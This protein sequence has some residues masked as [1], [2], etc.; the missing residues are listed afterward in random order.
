MPCARRCLEVSLLLEQKTHR[1]PKRNHHETKG[2]LTIMT[3]AEIRAQLEQLAATGASADQIDALTRRWLAIRA[4]TPATY[5][6][7][8]EDRLNALGITGTIHLTLE[9]I[10]NSCI[11]A[12][13][14]VW[15]PV[16]L[17]MREVI[18]PPEEF[19]N[20]VN[21]CAGW[22]D[23]S[24]LMATNAGYTVTQ[25][26]EAGYG[27]VVTISAENWQQW[28]AQFEVCDLDDET[29]AALSAG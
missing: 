13:S 15:G 24:H 14:L 17:Q 7:A 21:D 9:S 22:E 29:L 25:R 3:A 6:P 11:S 2:H 27:V 16:A 20:F 10:G 1:L 23:T 18:T 8:I 19:E 26:F 4:S 12:L 28:L 5:H